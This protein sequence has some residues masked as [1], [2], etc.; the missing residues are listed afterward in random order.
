MRLLALDIGDKRTG[1]S[2]S[3][4]TNTFAISYGVI[5][6][7]DKKELAAKVKNICEKE[8]I[9]K[10]VVGYPLKMDG[11]V[12]TRAKMIDEFISYL[13]FKTKL[14]VVRVDERLTTWEA[15]NIIKQQGRKIKDKKKIIDK[16]AAS[17]ILQSYL[18][19]L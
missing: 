15:N 18:D 11:T 16:I 9:T 5:V 3:D 12:G 7:G 2:I 10:I 6:T 8:N 17:V 1:V 4:P 13:E 19:E 14:P